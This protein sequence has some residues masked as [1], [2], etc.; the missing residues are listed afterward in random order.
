ML[1]AKEK[2]ELLELLAPNNGDLDVFGTCRALCQEGKS[3][4]AL[5]LAVFQKLPDA[6]V[7]RLLDYASTFLCR[8]P[9]G[10]VRPEKVRSH[11]NRNFH[12][13][14]C[15]VCG[16]DVGAGRGGVVH[17]G[18]GWRVVCASPHCHAHLE[19]EIEI[20]VGES[21]DVFE[22]DGDERFVV[23]L[24][25][26]AYRFFEKKEFVRRTLSGSWNP[27][28]MV[29]SVRASAVES[30]DVRE[31][32][33]ALGLSFEED[34]QAQEEP[35]T[36]E[37]RA[38][39]YARRVAWLISLARE[40]ARECEKD[41]E[42]VRVEFED[43]IAEA[44]ASQRRRSKAY[45]ELEMTEEVRERVHEAATFMLG[46][47]DGAMSRDDVGFSR[48]DASMARH[49]YRRFREDDRI[50]RA[51]ERMLARYHRQLSQTFP[52]LFGDELRLGA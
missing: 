21:T 42:R 4:L 50:D 10:P 12:A 2:K 6:H 22:A 8:H 49:L 11:R 3:E 41:I 45:P 44:L 34:L 31:Q 33:R 13:G 5:V 52:L 19:V 1:Y 40:L 27:T 25:P 43:Y 35:L 20:G 32:A 37:L 39:W 46:Q 29:W 30:D 18:R 47:C 15:Q 51:L 16:V 23:R 17:D 28:R 38:T 9:L 14:P 7:S 26:H 24:V 36:S 48:A